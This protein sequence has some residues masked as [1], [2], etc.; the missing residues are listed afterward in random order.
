[1]SNTKKINITAAPT[2]N[3]N[4]IKFMPPESFFDG[5]T[6]D[7]PTRSKAEGNLLPEE[8]FSIDGVVGVMVGSNF[9]SVTKDGAARWEDVLEDIR[10]VLDEIVG[11]GE[12]VVSDSSLAEAAKSVEASGEIA[13]RII[14]IL[15]EEIRPAVAMDGGDVAFKSF[16]NGVVT[17][18][19]QGACSNCPASTMTLKMGIENRLKE[20]I[21]EVEE[22]I[23]S[24]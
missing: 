2:P 20:E 16:E 18:E 9:V 5:G 7:F 1:M 22:V 10:S 4:T 6:I 21:P 14:T 12:Q 3:P 24:Q 15:N 13:Q 23:A 8:L 11:S 17:L 19:L